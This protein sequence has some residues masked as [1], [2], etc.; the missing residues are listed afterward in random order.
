MKA[1]LF[2]VFF[3]FMTFAED[4]DNT[5]S[6]ERKAFLQDALVEAY[7][8]E[9]ADAA[10]MQEE[11]Q[12][13]IMDALPGKLVECAFSDSGANATCSDIITVAKEAGI[14]QDQV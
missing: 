10:K 6:S 11:A 7:G 12:S 4:A 8:Q 5:I 13:Q 3:S 9:V 2:L 14:T 1:V